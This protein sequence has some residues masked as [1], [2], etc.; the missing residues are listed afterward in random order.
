M[1]VS[2]GDTCIPKRV[3]AAQ[4]IDRI[5]CMRKKRK[6]VLGKGEHLVYSFPSFHRRE[7]RGICEIGQDSV[8]EKRASIF[9]EMWLLFPKKRGVNK[10]I[11][12]VLPFRHDFIGLLFLQSAEQSARAGTGKWTFPSLFPPSPMSPK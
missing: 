9:I 2:N 7:R 1:Y 3:G 5:I 12:F 6:H 10:P 4:K 11:V 8:R